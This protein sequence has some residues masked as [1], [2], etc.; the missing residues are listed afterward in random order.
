MEE[1]WLLVSK[2]VDGVGKMT[3]KAGSSPCSW[4]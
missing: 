2:V 3:E 4:T 1:G